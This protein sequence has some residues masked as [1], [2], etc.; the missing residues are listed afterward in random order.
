MEDNIST[1]LTFRLGLHSLL[2]AVIEDDAAAQ[3]QEDSAETGKSDKTDNDSD[4]DYNKKVDS[5]I[6]YSDITELA[7]EPPPSE[8]VGEI[9]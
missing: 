8:E 5:A 4:E 2:S 7:E 9:I 6:D 1:I 3:A